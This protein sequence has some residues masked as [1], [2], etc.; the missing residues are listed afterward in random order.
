MTTYDE[1]R[2]DNQL[3]FP[4]YA[5]SRQVTRLYQPLLKKLGITYPQYLILLV[6]WEKDDLSVSEIGERLMLSSNTLTP[7]L[8]RMETQGILLRT[9]SSEDERIVKIALTSEGDK[10]REKAVAIPRDLGSRILEILDEKEVI[11]LV[12]T[13]KKFLSDVKEED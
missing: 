10:L 9:R 5:A 4:L 6:L 8:K 3:C 12:N 11:S 2:L 1:L 7:L 13:L